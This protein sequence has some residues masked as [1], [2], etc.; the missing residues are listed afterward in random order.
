MEPRFLDAGEAALVVEFGLVVDPAINDHVLALDRAL[1]SL[2]VPG[3]RETVPTFRSLMIHYDP[4]VIGRAALIE[5]VRNLE[6]HAALPRTAVRW[7]IPCCYEPPLGED[8]AQIADMVGL[9]PAGVVALHTAVE[10]RVYMYGFVP[11]FCY[12]GRL[13]ELPLS[14][15][16]TVRAPHPANTILV[17]DGMCVITTVSMPT[18]WWLIGRTPERLFAPAREPT[19][20]VGV[21]DALR[22]EAVDR[23]TFDALDARAEAGEVVARRAVLG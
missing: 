22:F 21:G 10:L 17:A 8:L 19:F 12:L 6:T 4:L 20:L 23:A 7:T 11:G 5:R 15:R 1:A 9:T 13:P 18:G 2:A 16:A 14:R 3:V